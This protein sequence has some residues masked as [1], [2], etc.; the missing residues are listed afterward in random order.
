[1]MIPAAVGPI[2]GPKAMTMPNSPMAVPCLSTGNVHMSTVMTSGMRIP[3]PAA[4][5][6]R[7]ISSTAK[8]GP[9][10]AS[11][12]PTVNTP[13]DTRNSRRVVNRSVRNA[14]MGIMMAFT[15][16]KPVVSH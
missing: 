4:C 6:R 3:A 2:A 13:M 9:Q 15:R 1:M 10:P 5:T 7:P 11:A 16:V 12:L 8:L 14:V